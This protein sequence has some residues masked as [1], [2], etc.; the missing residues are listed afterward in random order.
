MT[1]FRAPISAHLFGQLSGNGQLMGNSSCPSS[2]NRSFGVDAWR[3]VQF[4]NHV[5]IDAEG[6]RRSVPELAGH[7]DD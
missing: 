6:E 3:V 4:V 1:L 5:S 2:R 7:V